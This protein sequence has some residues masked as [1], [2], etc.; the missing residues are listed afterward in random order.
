MKILF[1]YKKNQGC[2]TCP[3]GYEPVLNGEGCLRQEVIDATPPTNPQNLDK[4]Q[5]LLYSKHGVLL[6]HSPVY[7]D[8]TA[9]GFTRYHTSAN[10][11]WAN[12]NSSS[13]VNGALNRAGLWSQNV[14]DYQ[15][16]GFTQCFDIASTKT[17]YLGIGADNYSSIYIDGVLFVSQN[18]AAM[19]TFLGLSIGDLIA[20]QLWH[21]YP[22]LL[23]EGRHVIHAIGNNTVNV[24]AVG[25]ELYDMDVPS[26]MDCYSYEEIGAGLIFSSK[27][28]VGQP[29]ELGNLGVG[30]S[31]PEGYTLAK[32]DGQTIP[33]CYL[34]DYIECP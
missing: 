10:N 7:L 13:L 9:A 2:T 6:Y 30:Y 8:G 31:C 5:H 17:Y 24:A 22:I 23:T 29:V 34:I 26:L 16:V 15:T 18:M 28:M 32:C 1:T 14:Y 21:I 25:V 11:F 20:H 19:N 3:E 33:Q 27:D 4:K 12:Y